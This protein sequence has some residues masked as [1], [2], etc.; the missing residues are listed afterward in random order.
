MA[1]LLLIA[2]GFAGCQRDPS[3]S[4]RSS[5][6][7]LKSP[8][9]Q[10]ISLMNAGKNYLDQGEATN[11][12]AVYRKAEAI[13]PHD[14]DLRLN[15]ANAF[16]MAGDAVEAIRESD[17]LLK[18]EPNSAAA[19]F[20]KGSAYLRLSNWEGAAMALENSKRI[21]PGETATFFQLGRARMGLKQWDEAIAAFKEGI[22]MDPNH[23]HRTAHYLLAQALLRAGRQEEARQELEQH[24]ATPEDAALPGSTA[25]FE[26][27]KHTQARVPF[28]LEQPDKSGTAIRFADATPE[29]LQGAAEQYSNP[30]VVIPATR[31]VGHSLF[32]LEKGQGFRLLSITNGTF[33]PQGI[34]SPSIPGAR[35]TKMLVGDLQNDRFNDLVVL[36]DKGS[37][38]FKLSTHE[39]P[40]DVTRASHL[41]S[42]SAVDGILLDLDFT[43]KLDLVAVAADT[44]AVRVYRQ[45]GPLL[46]NEITSTTGIPASL[47]DAQAVTLE[48]WNR[49]GNMDVIVSRKEGPPLL[50]EKQRGGRLVPREMTQWMAGAVFCTG[51]FDNDLRPDLAVASE[52]QIS[53]CF[54]GGSKKEIPVSDTSGLRQITAVDYDND[55]W[56]D[57]WGSGDGMRVWRNLGLSGFVEQTARL[58]LDTFDEGAVSEVCFADFD[59]DCD[60]DVMVALVN[61]GIRFLRNDGGNANAQVKVEL[62]GNRSNAS[63]LGCKVEIEAGGLRL[64]RTVQRLPV[65]IGVGQHQKL[66][67]FL[68]HWAN[69]PQGAADVPFHCRE[70][71]LALELT[72]QEGSCPYLYA[73]NGQCFRF[74]TDILGASPLGLPM[75]EGSYTAADPDEYV[76]IGDEVTFP[77]HDGHYQLQITEELR[78]VLYLDEAKLV[79]VDHEPGTEV[80]PTDKLLP[81]GPFPP[82]ILMTLHHEQ[83][84]RKAETLEGVEVTSALR[85][86]DGRRVSP[87][88]LRVPQLRGLAEP[89]GLIL[90][91]GPLDTAKP[92]VLVMNGWLRFGG[93]MAN[94]AASHDPSLPF[95]FPALEAEVAPGIWKPIDVIVGAPAGKTKTL[96]VD[97]GGKLEQNTHRLRLTEAF[98]IHWDRIALMEKKLDATTRLTF[99]MPAE[100]DLHFRG[101]SPLKNL[102]ADWPLTPDYHIVS[103]NS[104][105]TIIPG[106]WCTRYGDVLSLIASR[107][108]GLALINAGD[109]LTLKFTASSIPLKPAG[110][111][112][113]FFLYADGWDKDSD[114]HVA[115]GTEVGPLP[116]HGMR[117]QAYGQE[118]RPPFPS[119][120]LH[121]KY[122]TRWVEGRVLKQTV[123]Q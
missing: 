28:R 92:L 24:Q 14:A 9:E 33:R 114:F 88:R 49:D 19:Y 65:E 95:P 81:A 11:A 26:R 32:V 60:S 91:F 101:F 120:I 103:P 63:G 53:V 48:D 47:Q 116:F 59:M 64:L 36:G 62:T 113:D 7:T 78:E 97:L 118:K 80:H 94:I 77:P 123:K 17:K 18:I 73:W 110:R 35:Y 61:G 74:V 38:L 102:P 106:G 6:G 15:L 41:D 83:P 109:E 27:N 52:G 70:P 69:W 25:P 8:S 22:A 98:E 89:H 68:V 90:D 21:D 43:G 3:D 37:H 82:G 51:D 108:E 72:L 40:Q 86:V 5:S 96:L 39:A 56:L 55:G 66:D 12:L 42:V 34:A 99:V 50:L 1:C 71:L 29:V 87:P 10:F 76:W 111:L 75:A 112:R 100:A 44:N 30:M 4:S 13:A 119:D 107:D 84:L 58:G 31:T 121:Q 122:N 2:F 16:L 67:S 115:A 54:N 20:V 46:F 93:G 104:C 105:W 45:F 85:T 23:L 57:L 117:D 79:V